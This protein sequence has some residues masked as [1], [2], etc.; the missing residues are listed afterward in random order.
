MLADIELRGMHLDADRVRAAFK[1]GR[2]QLDVVEAELHEFTGG[3]NPRS[4]KQVAVYL[5]DTLGF[6]PPKINGKPVRGTDKEAIA[7]LKATTPEQERFLDLKKRHAVLEAE[8]GKALEK[9]N[10]CCNDTT[11]DNLLLAVFNQTITQ[12]HRLSSS[13]SKYKVQFQN[14]ARKFKPLFN[15]RN[16]GGKI[17]EPDGSQLEFRVAGFLGQDRR[18]YD[19][20]MNKVDGYLARTRV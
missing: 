1:A 11:S 6:D 19:D 7:R 10:D 3:I 18:A 20:I 9:F 8:V 15:A 16:P 13:G 12:T 2:E 14:F 4:P 5:Y 17:G